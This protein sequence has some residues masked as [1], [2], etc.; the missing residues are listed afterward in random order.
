M[1]HTAFE[2]LCKHA[3][4]PAPEVEYRF[5]SARRWR[6]DYAWPEPKYKIALEVEGAVWAQ[7]RHTRGSGF[8]KDMEKYNELSILGWRLLR[9]TPQQMK[10]L[11]V[12]DL[13]Q[14]IFKSF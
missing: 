11:E 7:G 3:G 6:L 1:Q 8:V 13:L 5:T 10:S 12:L 14:R 4:I 9:V 2:T